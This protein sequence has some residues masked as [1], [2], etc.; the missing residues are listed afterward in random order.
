MKIKKLDEYRDVTSTGNIIQRK[1]RRGTY[2]VGAVYQPAT[3]RYGYQ[4]IS[5]GHGKNPSRFHRVLWE[6]FNG[7]IPE[8]MQV[9]HI[10]GKKDD[11]R[12][13]NLRLVTNAEN[14]R[15][16]AKVVKGSSSK[17]RGVSICGRTNRWLASVCYNGKRFFVG[18][19]ASQVAAALARDI[20]ALELGYPVEGTNFFSAA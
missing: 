15:G 8:G 3:D 13:E 2:G 18:S 6:A 5:I 10:N 17:Y 20:K 4:V 7:P 9:D 19:F 16:Y 12:L 11:N 1:I 14:L